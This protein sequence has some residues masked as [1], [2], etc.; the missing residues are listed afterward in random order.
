MRF[1]SKLRSTIW[2]WP[3]S[4]QRDEFGRPIRRSK[5]ERVKCRWEDLN[6]LKLGLFA[7]DVE[8]RSRIANA[9]FFTATRLEVKGHVAEA[10]EE[11]PPMEIPKSAREVVEVV[12]VPNLRNNQSLYTVMV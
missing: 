7:E 12:T 9:R 6:L 2:Y 4:T 3:P 1:E 10:T 8:T 5:P 11:E